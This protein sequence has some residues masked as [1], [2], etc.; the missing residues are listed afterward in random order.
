[1]RF[2]FI[3]VA[4]FLTVAFLATAVPAYKGILKVSNPDGTQIEIRLHGD[5]YFSYATDVDNCFVYECS[6]GG[7]WKTAIRNGKKLRVTESD[8]QILKEEKSSGMSKLPA[9]RGRAIDNE[10]RSTFPTTGSDLKFLIVLLEYSDTPFTMEDPQELYTRWFNEEGFTYQDI[11]SS[12]RDYYTDASAGKFKPEFVVSPVVKLK[13]PSKYYTGSNN[14]YALFY[15]AIEEAFTQLNDVNFDF[16]PF[17]INNDGVLDNVYFVFAGYGQA[18]TGDTSTIWPHKSSVSYYNIYGGRLLVDSYAC[19]QELRGSAH[20]NSKDGILN[21]MG[22]F[23][24]EFGHVLGLPDLYDPE[25][26]VSTSDNLPGNW[27]IMCDGPY[28]NNSKTPPT[29]TAY[30]RWVCRWLELEDL[31]PDTYVLDALAKNN[32]AY[33]LSVPTT[34]ESLQEYYIFESRSKT[35][36]DSYI[37]GEGLLIWHIDYDFNSWNRNTVNGDPDHPRCTLMVPAGKKIPT[38]YWPAE[39]TYGK[40]IAPGYTNEFKP[41]NAYSEKF[42]PVVF[43]ISY[44]SDTMQSAFSYSEN[45]SEIYSEVVP[46]A[47]AF[48]FDSSSGMRIKWEAAKGAVKYHVTVK[49]YTSGGSSFIVDNYDNKEVEG[50][51]C[52]INESRSMM[53]QEHTVSIRAVSEDG[54]PSTQSY[55]M[56][57]FKPNSL[58]AYSSVGELVSDN[59]ISVA[60]GKGCIYAPSGSSVYTI[61]GVRTGMYSLQPGIYIVINGN[62]HYK[63]TVE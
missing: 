31:K 8:L 32:H 25:Y 38:G 59:V 27:T 43:D 19:S 13:E 58:E 34:D 51:E 36:F 53:A 49:R 22:T 17:D 23:C 3:L 20:Y 40:M 9:I 37:P 63:V 28:L 39:E 12:P 44:D 47:I 11:T 62:R 6:E 45:T 42:S 48:K 61:D 4:L 7:Y 1:M 5:E 26:K 55:D 52:D 29:Y 14:K 16:T 35:G 2:R 46:S 24:H 33:R 57:S 54:T 18:D 50:L 60:G 21:G 10:G 30:E 41:F 15:K 56:E